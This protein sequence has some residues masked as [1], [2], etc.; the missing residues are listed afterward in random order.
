MSDIEIGADTRVTLHFSLKFSDGSIIDSN[1]DKKPATFTV[2]DGS[3]LPG[4]EQKII[5]MKAGEQGDFTV[6]P[7]QSFGQP[8][9]NNV[10]QFSRK[11]FS[12]DMALEPGLVI[13]FADAGQ[14]ELPGVVKSVDGDTVMVDF[15]HPLAGRDIQFAV[16][17]IAVETVQVGQV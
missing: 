16:N 4:F 3:L 15:N 6:L 9:P 10:Q 7:Q 8:N 13:S 17:I 11:D 2:G 5:G 12:A 14:S 1:F